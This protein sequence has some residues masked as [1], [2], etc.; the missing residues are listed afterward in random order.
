MPNFTARMTRFNFGWG[1]RFLPWCMCHLFIEFCE[2]C[3]SSFCIILL[4]VKQTNGDKNI[5]YMYLA[6]VMISY[7]DIHN[8]KFLNYWPTATFWENKFHAVAN[9]SQRSPLLLFLLKNRFLAL[10]LQ[11]ILIDLD[12]ILHTPRGSGIEGSYMLKYAKIVLLFFWT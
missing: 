9:F 12:K 6:E 8:D 11:I 2:T 7:T 1:W 10:I 5:T 3:W 4:A